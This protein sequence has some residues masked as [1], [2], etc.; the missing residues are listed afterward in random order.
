M[1]TAGLQNLRRGA[2]GHRYRP[3]SEPRILGQR[4]SLAAR[5]RQAA[6]FSR[7][8]GRHGF[9]HHHDQRAR[10]GRLGR[11]RNRG[12]G[13][14]ART[15]GL[16]PHPRSSRRPFERPPARRCHR[17]R[18]RASR[19]RTPAQNKGR[20]Q[21]CRVLRG[22]GCF[23][24]ATRS[25]DHRQ[26][27]SGIRRDHGI[28]PG[29]R[30]VGQL[31]AR[32]RP[33]GR[34]VRRLRG[35]L[36][37]AANVRHAAQGRDRLQRGPRTRSRISPAWGGR[38]ETAAGPHQSAGSEKHFCFAPRK[39]GGRWRLQQTGVG[40]RC[41]GLDQGGAPALRN[42]CRREKTGRGNGG[43]SSH[44]GQRRRAG[45]QWRSELG[46]RQRGDCRHHQLHEHKQSERHA[47]CRPSGQ[48]SRGARAPCFARGK[49]VAR[50]RFAGGA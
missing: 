30:R 6:L 46:S 7:H 14:H 16:F 45:G 1:G 4:C 42:S 34:A 36:Q 19:H 5:R 23:A 27:G 21:I 22:G 12:R 11:R 40:P 10:C 33:H 49:D 43:G 35:L 31:S 25:C 37:G 28:L 3:P 8:V 2:S 18:S 17:D 13:G 9:A 44:A 32:H 47:W 24:A 50:P 41:G 38:S 15:T 26:H 48:E 39:T 29:R 20:R